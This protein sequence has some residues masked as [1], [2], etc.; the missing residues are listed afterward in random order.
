MKMDKI[1]Y[2]FLYLVLAMSVMILLI[3]LFETMRIDY[4]FPI[5]DILV[6]PGN[7]PPDIYDDY[8]ELKNTYIFTNAPFIAIVNFIG[9]VSILGIFIISWMLGRRSLP[10]KLNE[11]L[12]SYSMLLILT[13]YFVI[14]IFNYLVDVFLNQILALL[15]NDIVLAIYMYGLLITYFP[16]LVLSALM[17]SFISNQIKYFDILRS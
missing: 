11:V 2:Y 4:F 6:N 9:L 17:L 16:W 13:F 7:T 5:G 3:G 10:F 14:I 12:N 8:L 15:F 1:F